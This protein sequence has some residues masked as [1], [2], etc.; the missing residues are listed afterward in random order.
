VPR[1]TPPRPVDVAAVFPEL[2]D[3]AARATRL[4]P[5][6]GTPAVTDSSVGGPLLWPVDEPWPMCTEPH[7]DVDVLLR[8]DTVR[9]WRAIL[10]AAWSRT[11]RG[12]SLAITDAERA[13]LPDTEVSEPY[14]L[15]RQP[16]AMVPV[17][18]AH[19]RDVPG[20]IGPPGAD[21]LQVLWCPLGHADLE[22]CP[23][24]AVRWRRAADVGEVL[25]APPEPAVVESD[26]YLPEPC[27]LHPEQ[28]TEYE[29]G[30]LLPAAL[31]ERIRAWENGSGLSYQLDLSIAPGWKI[32]GFASWHLSDPRPMGCTACGTPMRLLL[33]IA[34]AEW[35]GDGTWRPVEDAGEHG[36]A[37][38][39]PSGPTGV[40]IGRGYSL[41]VFHCPESFDHPPATAMQ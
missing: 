28:V 30:G 2:H 25:A 39:P 35:D 15:A 33:T 29:Y 22:Y 23:R 21:L 36:P 10:S 11:E 40:E 41:W 34:T 1:T 37:L 31:H 27:V 24:P 4:H 13:A 5:R 32:G 20:F 9:R 17:L 3:H 19:R 7:D 18:Q 38:F 14:E 26:Y 8:P 6:P 16:I 12:A